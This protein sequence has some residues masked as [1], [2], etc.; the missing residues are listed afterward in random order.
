[1]DASLD[2]LRHDGFVIVPDAVPQELLASLDLEIN[3]ALA[4]AAEG[5]DQALL[6]DCVFERDL[7]AAKRGERVVPA[8]CG[9]VFILG[10]LAEHVP[11]V[12]QLLLLAGVQDLARTLLETDA[13]VPHFVN[14]TQKS[15][16]T[17]SGISW[18]RDYPNRYICPVD[19]VMIRLMLCLDGMGEDTGATQFIRGS[20]HSMPDGSLPDERSGAVP[21]VCGPGALVAIHPLVL[22]GGAPNASAMRRRNIVMQWG[23]AGAALQPGP[24]EPIT[25]LLPSG[26]E[27][28]WRK[29]RAERVA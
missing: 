16:R 17:G 23:P 27:T 26:L 24:R 1:M 6:A 14:L 21:A 9:D 20:H 13:A 12:L 15:A 8:E 28:L 5:R 19:P 11:S 3:A 7:P 29:Q 2:R 25:G 4:R 22:H 10:N 18:H